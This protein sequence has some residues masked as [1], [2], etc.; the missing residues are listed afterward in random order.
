MTAGCGRLVRPPVTADHGQLG[1][2]WVWQRGQP[3]RSRG[4]SGRLRGDSLPSTQLLPTHLSACA[5]TGSRLPTRCGGISGLLVAA[6][7]RVSSNQRLHDLCIGILLINIDVVNGLNN[8]SLSWTLFWHRE[9][10]RTE[11]GLVEGRR[12]SE[13]WGRLGSWVAG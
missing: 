8:R 12:T 2:Q 5:Y 10:Q 7:C 1:G 3:R 9:F 4:G 6:Y 13:V 11:W